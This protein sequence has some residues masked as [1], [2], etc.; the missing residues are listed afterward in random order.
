[1]DTKYAIKSGFIKL[2]TKQ[3]YNSI[4]VQSL[5]KSVPIARTTFYAHYDNI[6][7]VKAEIEGE[8]VREIRAVSEKIYSDDSEATFA[9]LMDYIEQN[10]SV[11]YAFLA[12]QPNAR[13][14]EKLKTAIINHFKENFGS[15]KGKNYELELEI[16]ASAVITYYTY[17]LKNPDKTDT[18][19]ISKKFKTIKKLIK[20]VL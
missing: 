8:T 10:R 20:S 17:W 6:D 11:F 19:N 5:C 13:F 2:Y 16:F 18:E 15:N 9:G 3:N 1:M 14:I 4:T 7:C 12:A